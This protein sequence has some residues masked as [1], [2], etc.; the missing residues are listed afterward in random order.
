[1][2]RK[3]DDGAKP[4]RPPATT[5]E[6][7]ENQLIAAATDLAEKQLRDGTA[8][9]QVVTHY[10]K[11]GSSREQLEQARLQGEVELQKAR[12]DQIASAVRMEEMFTEA[13]KAMRSYQGE[14]PELI[15]GEFEEDYDER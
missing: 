5:P 10:L 4:P 12:I 6:A 3:N 1:M 9:A 15:E 13:I 11:L 2:A 8:S 7:R 14:E